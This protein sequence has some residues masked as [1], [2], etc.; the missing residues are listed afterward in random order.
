MNKTVA[1]KLIDL[2]GEKTQA[3]IAQAIGVGRSTYSMYENGMRIPSDSVKVKL[4]DFFKVT[5]QEL[6]FD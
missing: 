5:V 6:F 1:D 2:R 4:A 3:E